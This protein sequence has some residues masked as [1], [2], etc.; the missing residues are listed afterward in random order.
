MS[1][2]SRAWTYGL[3]SRSRNRP[4]LSRISL[5]CS[6]SALMRPAHLKFPIER[7]G[8]TG[9]GRQRDKPGVALALFDANQHPFLIALLRRGG[10]LLDMLGAGE[11]RLP[12]T[13]NQIAG[14]HAL[15]GGGAVRRNLGN[16][17]SLCPLGQRELLAQLRRDLGEL[18]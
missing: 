5:S 8:S 12:D 7:P 17:R 16:D 4:T 1:S 18:Q 13:D 6:A 14:A 10:E 3:T 11:R 2:C 15:R 9:V